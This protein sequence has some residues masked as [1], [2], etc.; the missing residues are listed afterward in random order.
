L[1][2]PFTP[3]QVILCLR[4]G[5]IIDTSIVMLSKRNIVNFLF[6]IGFPVHGIGSFL[7]LKSPT[8][9][10]IIAVLPLF[11]ILVFY[12]VDILY[13]KEFKVRL[14]GY[15]FLALIF[16]ISSAMALYIA[17]NKHLPETNSWQIFGKSLLIFIPLH[18]FIVVH[19]YN[20]D[21]KNIIPKLTLISLSLLLFINLV[22]FFVFGLE[23]GR[24]SFEGRISFPFLAGLYSGASLLA[25]INLM[26]L[27]F[28]ESFTKNPLR[29]IS[30]TAFFMMNM[31]MLFF[32]P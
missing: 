31:A 6:I 32:M 1:A 13:K 30:A 7:S 11:A 15:Y 27:F 9:G 24:H 22:G 17:L 12:A 19:L 25:I 3:I 23:N 16:L 21:D 29:F 8:V 28:F 20:E 5:I 26:L 2:K 14:N 10:F 4:A 18:A